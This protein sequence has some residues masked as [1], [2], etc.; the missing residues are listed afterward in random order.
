MTCQHLPERNTKRVEI[1]TDIY[2]SSYN[3]FWT[4]ELWCSGKGPAPRD[5]GLSIGFINC[6][7]QAK[8]DN[9][10]C[11]NALL[12][13]AHHDIA[14]F[15]V[16]VNE[17]FLVNRSQTGGDLRR[18]V[19]S[20]LY[21][22]PA[23]ALD[24]ILQGFSLHKL[25]G[26]EVALGASP[27]VEDRGNIRVPDASRCACF[28]QETK[29]R[30]FVTEILLADDFQCHRASKVDVERFVSDPHRAVTQFDRSLVFGD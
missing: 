19:Q 14:R 16:P 22:K 13:K 12:L 29:A 23:R 24:E 11:H 26:V 5:R 7:G 17:L 8:I 4:G 18:N 25:H 28:T 15:D 10:G 2:L 6:L 9:L 20:Q 1:R 30:R 3:L 21:L 27:Q